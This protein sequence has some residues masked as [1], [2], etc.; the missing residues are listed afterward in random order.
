M[1]SKNKFSLR[2]NVKLRL[3]KDMITGLKLNHPNV[4]NFILVLDPTTTR[5]VSSCIKMMDLLEEGVVAIERL[6]LSR[7][8]FPKMHAIY[9]LSPVEESINSLLKDFSNPKDPQYGNIHLFFTN[10]V[11]DT[12][13]SKLSGQKPVI[14]R[15]LTF[16]ELN[17]DFLSPEANLFHLD[18]KTEFA[19]I[20]CN[21]GSSGQE[22]RIAYKL[23]TVVPTLFDFEKFH[24]IY[25]KNRANM[26]AENV[27]KLLKQRIDKFL[28]IKKKKDDDGDKEPAAPVK[29]VILDRSYDPLTPLVHD[30]YYQSLVYDLLR[31]E[32]DTVEYET[33]DNNKKVSKK[34]TV[35]TDKDELWGKFRHQFI[36]EAMINIS[37]EFE[38]FVANNRTAKTQK[39]DM[40]NLNLQQMSD[41]VKSMPMYQEV[42]GK[43]TVHMS[44]IQ[45]CVRIFNEQELK[46]IGDIE[47]S[48]VTHFDG[49]G[50]P[51][52]S[53]KL[54]MLLSNKFASGNLSQRMKLRLLMIATISLELSDKDRKALT[55]HLAPEEKSI[56]YKLTW[57]G[58][59]P[60][61]PSS[62]SGKTSK[63]AQGVSLAA[64]N[65][66]KNIST[67][68]LRYTP[69]LETFANDIVSGNNPTGVNCGNIFIPSTY[70][71]SVQGTKA[72]PAGGIIAS[73][74]RGGAARPAT[75]WNENLDERLQPKYVFFIIGGM[76]YTEVRVLKEIEKTNP[77]VT[78]IMGATS[79]IK[80]DEYIDGIGLMSD[81]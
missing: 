62:S 54:F 34:K 79:F 69:T 68:L 3:L 20:F 48:L 78:I 40:T 5:I 11:E 63:K 72:K 33:E 71:G 2:E 16:K 65:K 77:N 32:N 24:I 18:M 60:K 51:L 64:K 29:I 74:R 4:P 47:Q 25:N 81:P 38:E 23:A 9:F 67:D 61:E 53:Q 46:E 27:A 28:E 70:D 57:L 56:L 52:T 21:P 42:L 10:H 35:L 41:I 12:L 14:E 1:I 55:Q 66:L 45:E 15:V 6:E 19:N 49:D 43:Y 73:L 30:Y 36:G 80:P 22:Q 8:Q 44:L 37:K 13:V 59:D 39:G 58:V 76:S 26:I 7:K 17:L 50:K 75:N 31:V